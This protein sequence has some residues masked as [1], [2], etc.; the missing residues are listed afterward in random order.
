MAVQNRQEVIVDS[1]VLI[2]FLRVGRLDLLA[3]HPQ[4][5][6]LVTEHVR[7]EITAEF[8][9]QLELLQRSLVEG[10]IEEIRVEH[11]I[12]LECFAKLASSGRLGLG[13]CSAIAEASRRHVPVAIDDRAA[14]RLGRK[15][16]Q[17]LRLLDTQALVVSMIRTRLLTLDDADALKEVW[18]HKHRFKLGLRSFRDAMGEDGETAFK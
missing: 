13:E 4:Y 8:P 7:A 1:S 18:E 10:G 2:N 6:F 15:L 11:P 12:A 16:D 3:N 5:R 17:N 9:E 14:R